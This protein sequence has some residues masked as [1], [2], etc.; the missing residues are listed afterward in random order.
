MSIRLLGSFEGSATRVGISAATDSAEDR[1]AVTIL[2]DLPS[3]L[4][5]D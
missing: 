3:A 4:I 5:A 2:Q 1:S